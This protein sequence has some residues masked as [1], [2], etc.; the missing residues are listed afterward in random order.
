[1]STD[2]GRSTQ[3]RM[4]TLFLDNV[5]VV[6]RG[7]PIIRVANMIVFKNCKFDVELNGI[8]SDRTRTLT[9]NPLASGDL[10]N[11]QLPIGPMPS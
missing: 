11:I 3:L 10:K 7:S 1:M 2:D 8:P 9:E 5:D 4:S 6:L